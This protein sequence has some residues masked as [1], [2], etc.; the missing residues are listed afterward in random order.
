MTHPDT[1]PSLDIQTA[2]RFLFA[3]AT[4]PER[5]DKAL[6]SGASVV[7]VDLEDAVSLADK[8]SARA[9]LPKAEDAAALSVVATST[10]KP[11][12]PIILNT[13]VTQ[14]QIGATARSLTA[15]T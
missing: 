6:A 8:D 13:S 2:C 7:I 14:S 9:T 4:C 5:I 11:V 10:G 12:L 3:P 1:A 15:S